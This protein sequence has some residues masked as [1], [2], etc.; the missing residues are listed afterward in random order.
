MTKLIINLLD[1]ASIAM[2]LSVLNGASTTP[3][4]VLNGAS[5]TPVAVQNGAQISTNPENRQPTGETQTAAA[6]GLDTTQPDSAGVMWNPEFHVSPAKQTAS[7]K[8]SVASG[9][10]AAL[11][12]FLEQQ[13]TTGQTPA[14]VTQPDTTAA[15]ANNAMPG[16]G[17]MPGMSTVPDTPPVAPSYDQVCQKFIELNNAGKIPDPF[18]FYGSAGITDPN[19]LITNE[20]DRASL[21]AAMAAIV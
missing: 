12:A 18:A 15:V 3:V 20:T 16:M 13:T 9:K 10:A 5:A 21:W 11:K 8:W 17:G 1:S 6:P 19:S 7:G 14:A 4:A 2:G